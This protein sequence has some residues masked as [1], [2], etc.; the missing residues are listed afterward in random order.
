MNNCI[1]MVDVT[2]RYH[3]TEVVKNVTFQIEQGNL[4]A[5][6]G[7]NGAGKS[8]TLNMIITLLQKSAGKIYVEG[9]DIDI[10]K[11]N[12]RKRIGVVFQEDILDLELSVYENLFFRGGLYITDKRQLKQHIQEICQLLNIANIKEKRYQTCSGGQRRLVQIAR[13][14]IPEPQ[15]LIL[16]EP[17]VG[18]DPLAREQVWKVLT[19]LNQERNLTIFY[20]THYMEEASNADQVIMIHKG[21]LLLCQKVKQLCSASSKEYVSHQLQELYLNLLREYKVRRMESMN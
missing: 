8:T 2:K 9:L 21:N 1:K 12:I 17:T 13:A 6:L 4:C 14:L 11:E 15:L 5:F 10:H 7:S 19:K 18:L 3:K 16:D 20:S